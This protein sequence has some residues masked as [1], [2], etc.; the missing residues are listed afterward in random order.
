MKIPHIES[1]LQRCRRGEPAAQRALFQQAY[2]YGLTVALFYSDNREDA[3]ELLQDSFLRVFRHLERQAPPW[4]F[5]PWFRRIIIN[6]AIDY[7]RAKQ[8][9]GLR[10]ALTA[11]HSEPVVNEAVAALNQADLYRLVQQLPTAYRL[12]FNLHVLEGYTH[13][14]IARQLG[15]GVGTSKSNLAK[16]RKHLQRLAGPH[17]SIDN[18][19]SNA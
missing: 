17:F 14:E 8:S 9:N 18:R 15:I 7:Y 19:L 12:V 4:D 3:E 1:I 2:G 10:V 13:R 16:A 6:R 5:K 11:I